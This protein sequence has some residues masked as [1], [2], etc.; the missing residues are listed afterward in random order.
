MRPNE[1]VPEWRVRRWV[2]DGPASLASLRGRV[3]IV[4]AFQMLCPGCIY[5][6]IPQA[7][8]LHERL[9][10][11][12]V[13]LGLH[14]V[15]EHHD[16]MGDASL[17]AFLAELRVPFPVGVDAHETPRSHPW[18]MRRW[19]LRGTP[20]TVVIDRAGRLAWERFGSEDDLDV[21]LRL[22]QLL[23]AASEG[24]DGEVCPA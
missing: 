15:F 3:V 16:A 20:S 24:C 6:G 12:A 23:G 2:G 17:E 10:G 22:G 14:T 1:P 7:V 13:V 4:H 18:T 9:G 11:D 21:G 19:G 5:R 8:R